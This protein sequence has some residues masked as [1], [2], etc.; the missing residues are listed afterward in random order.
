M[1]PVD[2]EVKRSDFKWLDAIHALPNV[3]NMN[4]ENE[5]DISKATF[6]VVVDGELVDTHE[7]RKRLMGEL[8]KRWHGNMV[9]FRPIY[10]SGLG[11][12][13][14]EG[15]S[16]I[17]MNYHEQEVRLSEH[18]FD[19]EVIDMDDFNIRHTGHVLI[20][21]VAL[22]MRIIMDD[23][24]EEGQ[25]DDHIFVRSIDRIIPV[26]VE[27]LGYDN[28]SITNKIVLDEEENHGA[29]LDLEL[30]S[31]QE[32]TTKRERAIQ[33]TLVGPIAEVDTQRIYKG[34]VN[35]TNSKHI[36]SILERDNILPWYPEN[37]T[38]VSKLTGVSTTTL[39]ELR[40]GKKDVNRLLVDTAAILTTYANIRYL[41]AMM[42]YTLM[43]P[44]I[45]AIRTKSDGS[46]LL[47]FVSF[48]YGKDTNEDDTGDVE[49][50]TIDDSFNDDDDVVFAY[51]VILNSGTSFSFEY[52]D[53]EEGKTEVIELHRRWLEYHETKEDGRTGVKRYDSKNSS[54]SY[55]ADHPF[56]ASVKEGLLFVGNIDAILVTKNISD[57][58]MF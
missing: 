15:I 3:F 16:G 34:V 24:T 33:H 43:N 35:A 40:H 27:Y 42:A 23:Y 56:L 1:L 21:F 20:D 19:V 49:Q 5:T 41:D 54:H 32:D 6:D 30:V 36:G 8:F 38:K 10:V 53:V 25:L 14:I 57:E 22:T 55:F 50:N 17:F 46:W 2:K 45:R 47:N 37:F 39:S 13:N 18:L 26:D 31:D 9:L 12:V 28:F 48:D 7:P 58:F 44:A 4:K 29:R 11:F 52:Q 51:D